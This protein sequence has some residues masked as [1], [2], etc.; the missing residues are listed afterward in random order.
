ML[1]SSE[2]KSPANL[3]ERLFRMDCRIKSGNDAIK[4]CSRDAI[5]PEFCEATKQ[6]RVGEGAK[7]RAHVFFQASSAWASLAL[8]PPYKA[9][10]NK[11]R[12]AER[13]K[14]HCPTNIRD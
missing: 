5:A 12:E 14:A 7:R 9:P 3:F 11:S 10:P 1:T 2:R 6:R 13:R 4:I 8:S